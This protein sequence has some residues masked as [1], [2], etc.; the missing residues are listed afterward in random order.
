MR[1]FLL[2]SI[3][4]LVAL[5]LMA[6]T[7]TVTFAWDSHPESAAIDGFKLYQTKQSMN[8]TTTPVATYTPGALTTG[9]IPKPT[10]FGRYYF[11]LTAFKTDTSVSPSVLIE[12]D[13]SNEVS[14]VVKPKAPVLKTAILTALMAPVKCIEKMAGLFGGG[15]KQLKIVKV[16]NG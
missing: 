9:T 1:K 13:Y 8:Y 10:S 3:M 12:S 16:S 4:L 6:Q 15:K 7:G 14:L 5:P 2:F 11:V